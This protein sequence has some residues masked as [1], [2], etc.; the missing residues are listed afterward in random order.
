MSIDEMDDD[1][2]ES[3]RLAVPGVLVAA[4]AC[5]LVLLFAA[6]TALAWAY[7]SDVPV[8]APP[9][10]RPF[11]EPQLRTDEAAQLRTLLAAQHRRLQGYRWIDRQNRTVGIPIE[12]AMDIIARRGAAAYD[13]L[14]AGGPAKPEA[15]P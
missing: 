3:P 4:A 15:T 5:C 8:R 7:R 6:I 13:P 10:P 1:G 14:A 2:L 11:P 12:R 9:P